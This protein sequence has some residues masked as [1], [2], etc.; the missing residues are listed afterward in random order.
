VFKTPPYSFHQNNE[1]VTFVLHVSH[2]SLDTM[3]L[4][5]N[6]N[7]VRKGV[8]HSDQA[9]SQGPKR[10]RPILVGGGGGV[11][12]KRSYQ[13]LFQA[14]SKFFKHTWLCEY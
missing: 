3:S 5:F 8:S 2:V 13:Y 10:G 4:G 11:S 12:R 1:S 6:G 7:K 9:F 14:R